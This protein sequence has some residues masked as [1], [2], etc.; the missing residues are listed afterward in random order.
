MTLKKRLIACLLW[1][2]GNIV[3]SIGFRH[4]NAVGNAFTSVEFFTT[5]AIDEIVIL[6]VTKG[7]HDRNNFYQI[8]QELSKRCFV[9][10]SVGGHI[11]N[12]EEIKILLSKGADKIIINTLAHKDPNFITKASKLFGNQ[13]IVISIDAKKDENNNHFV[14]INQG[15]EKTNSTALDWAKKVQELGGGEIFLTSIDND[16]KRQGYDLELINKISKSVD[17]PV[18]ASGGVG[19]WEHLVEGIKAGAD[20]VSA[21]NIFHYTEQSTKLA[22]EFMKKEGIEVRNPDFFKI[23]SKRNVIYRI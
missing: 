7:N 5:W 23:T 18:I 13:C 9:P 20:A 19:K 17:I 2:D 4:T 14:Y 16:G 15:K 1:N 3:Q 12:L 10:L 6:D 11:K 8:I 21:A 22:K